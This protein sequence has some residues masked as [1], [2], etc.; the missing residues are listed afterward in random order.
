MSVN[1]APGM[2]FPDYELPDDNGVVHRL[3]ELQGVSMNRL[4]TFLLLAS[5]RSD[6][7]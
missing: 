7:A 2:V 6:V 1:L 5:N 4:N 3:S